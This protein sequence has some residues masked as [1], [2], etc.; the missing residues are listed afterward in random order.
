MMVTS[1]TTCCVCTGLSLR[2][3]PSCSGVG[4]HIAGFAL[5]R[6]LEANVF[7]MSEFF[8]MERYRR[9]GFGAAAALRLFEHFQ[10]TWHVATHANNT[11]A[12]NFW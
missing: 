4:E 1:T 11:G 8:I 7:E 6:E 12:R 2:V 9:A 10:G 5:V 3:T